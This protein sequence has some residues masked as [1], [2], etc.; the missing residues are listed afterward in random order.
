MRNVT[1]TV[2]LQVPYLYPELVRV[3]IVFSLIRRVSNRI[4]PRF[5]IILPTYLNLRANIGS[6][7]SERI[8]SSILSLFLRCLCLFLG[9]QNIKRV[10]FSDN[11]ARI[12]DF[13]GYFVV[14]ISTIWYPAGMM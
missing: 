3:R 12:Y 14:Y 13:N 8:S 1:F 7:L 10:P 2:Y 9:F 6:F 4:D 11:L 5:S